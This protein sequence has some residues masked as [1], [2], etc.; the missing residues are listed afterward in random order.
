MAQQ[1]EAAKDSARLSPAVKHDFIL[2]S[3]CKV[4]A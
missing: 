2:I 1:V 4:L 3:Y